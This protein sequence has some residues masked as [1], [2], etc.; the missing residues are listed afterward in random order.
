MR[1]RLA[2]RSRSQ[3][4]L[5]VAR[6]SSVGAVSYPVPRA[7]Y[8]AVWLPTTCWDFS[9]LNFCSIGKNEGMF[10]PE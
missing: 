2:M 6:A 8:F 4:G 5:L 1:T 7:G 10:H 3:C 9:P